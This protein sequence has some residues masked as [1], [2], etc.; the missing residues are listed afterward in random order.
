MR[1]TICKG[2][3]KKGDCN[4]DCKRTA[5]GRKPDKKNTLKNQDPKLEITEYHLQ[6]ELLGEMIRKARKE[7]LMS[8]R[9]L[10]LLVGIK[11]SQV[12]RIENRLPVARFDS[13]I[14]VFKGLNVK[15]NFSV[16]LPDQTVTL[17]TK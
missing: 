5:P 1:K 14:K 8:R 10:G 16:E 13:I 11:E 3:C 4:G 7:R 12:S 17:T 15:V 2:G 6:F 9:E